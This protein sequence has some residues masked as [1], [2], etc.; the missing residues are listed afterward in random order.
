MKRF[1]VANPLGRSTLMVTGS[2]MVMGCAVKRGTVFL[3]VSP[4]SIFAG[5]VVA[6]TLYL[7]VMFSVRVLLP[8]S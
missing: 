7:G 3:F 4:S 1:S 6:F 2:V 8:V 5:L